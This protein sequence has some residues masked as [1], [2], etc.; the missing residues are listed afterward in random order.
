MNDD[1]VFEPAQLEPS[2]RFTLLDLQLLAESSPESPLRVV[3]LVDYD[4][5]YAQ[6][7][8]VRLGL[9]PSK[10]LAVRQWNAIIALNYPAKQQ[11]LKR[12]ISVDEAQ[13]LCPDITLQHIPTWREGDEQWRYRS[14]ILDHLTTDKASLEP[15]RDVSRK[16]IHLVKEMLPTT[17]A[18]RI[19]RASVDEFYLDLSAQVHEILLQRF[20]ALKA[21]AD[22]P[23]RNLP[24]PEF[25]DTLLDWQDDASAPSLQSGNPEER[26]DWDDVVLNIGASIVRDIRTEIKKRFKLTTSAGISHNKLLAK[27]ASRINK[28]A[29][30]T[31]LTHAS[32]PSVLGKLK[33]AALPGLGGQLGQKLAD[34]FESDSIFDLLQVPL[35][36]LRTQLG[37]EQGLWVHRA[38]RG[39]ERGA[40]R[41]RGEVQSLLSTKT[42]VPP[43]KNVQQAC[44]WLR[45]FSMD[46]EARLRDLDADSEFPRRP[47]TI[48]VHH[49]I[50]GR[51][52]PTRSKQ[53]PLPPQI[54][55]TRESIFDLSLDLLKQLVE[56]EE[57]WP[58]LS[59][60]AV[61]RSDS[62]NIDAAV[63]LAHKVAACVISSIHDGRLCSYSI[64]SATE[65][66]INLSP[67]AYA[68]LSRTVAEDPI[69][70][71]AKLCHELY[72]AP[73]SPDPNTGDATA[74]I[75]FKLN[76]GLVHSYVVKIFGNDI[77]N[78]AQT[79]LRQCKAPLRSIGQPPVTLAT[80]G[81][82]LF[83]DAAC[84][85]GALV[86]KLM[87][88]VAESAGEV[89][90][91]IGVN[92]FH[93]ST[94]NLSVI[95]NTQRCAA[96]PK[97]SAVQR[98]RPRC[99]LEWT[100]VTKIDLV[101][102]RGNG[103]MACERASPTPALFRF[104]DRKS[105]STIM[106]Q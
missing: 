101:G 66:A 103:Y 34:I 69:V 42:F 87:T 90:L 26:M 99:I 80:N 2:S 1:D 8:T 16:T 102:P 20:P 63:A 44:R 50:R 65:C 77:Y 27:V 62:S 58:C 24:L 72:V 82:M 54:E 64:L 33:A 67:T 59:I 37:A 40:V 95:D 56:H 100:L 9:P 13:R 29:R 88:Y 86:K 81:S 89:R 55:I 30:Q 38:L 61:D 28:P 45:I 19:E 96:A 25:G 106:S 60:S 92:I 43:I 18:P 68:Q 12:S 84:P 51:F 75:R 35:A 79:I 48:A 97:S 94:S 46:L 5:F 98:V 10:P 23:E 76:Q 91:A 78:K 7:E 21:H 49:H 70:C 104:G 22:E 14:D 52:G 47:R 4:A 3:A 71:A 15:Y 36:T 93:D 17:P 105:V 57:S 73:N 6:Y 39:D 85:R 83:P 74:T 32:A 53:A 11:G 31:I 41:A